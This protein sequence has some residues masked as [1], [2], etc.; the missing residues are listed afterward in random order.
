LAQAFCSERVNFVFFSPSS[1]STV[2]HV[3]MA[4][5]TYSF[6]PLQHTQSP[7]VTGSSVIALKYKDGVMM[8]AD[9]LASYGSQA[10]YKNVCRMKKLGMYTLLGESGEFSD[11]QYLGNL[12]DELDR[13]DFLCEDSCRMGPKEYASYVGRVMY[14][15]RSKMNPLFNQFLVAGKKKDEP[16]ILFY[17]DHQGTAFEEDYTATGF[18][19]HLAMPL[20]R[21]EW[22]ADLSEAEARALVTKCLEVCFYR[23]CRAYPKVQISIATGDPATTKI[24][25]PFL[26]DHKWD[27]DFYLRKNLE[28]EMKASGSTW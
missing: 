23:D 18:G 4:P 9:T 8:A 19:M 12:C 16:S 11:F 5:V 2:V 1:S 3:T 21:D 15:R 10:R 25:E 13:E 20:L 22:R 14:N 27:H 28:G 24:E 26:L 7:I 17:V 6:E